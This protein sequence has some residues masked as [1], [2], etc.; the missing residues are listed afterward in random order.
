MGGSPVSRGRPGAGGAPR[1]RTQ[2]A[3][4]SAPLPDAVGEVIRSDVPKVRQ[5]RTSEGRLQDVIAPVS[6]GGGSR[7]IAV[8]YVY[9]YGSLEL[10]TTDH[11][12]AAVTAALVL[13]F[14]GGLLSIILSRGLIRPVKV[15]SRGAA[16][17]AGGDRDHRIELKTG[18][19]MEHLALQF[20]RMVDSLSRKQAD[21]EAANVEL[22]EANTRLRE[23][24]AQL[25]RSERLA[26]LGQLSAGVS[27][28]LDNPVGVILGYAELIREEEGEGSVDEYASII[29]EEAKR[30]KRIIAGLLDFSRPSADQREILDI[31]ILIRDLVS[32]LGEQRTFRD[33]RWE[34]GNR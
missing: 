29:L 6:I 21:L 33:I 19:E 24:Q 22:T 11:I 12:R 28:E 13:M 2:P 23:L 15:L 32:Q 26:A 3:R 10:R 20:N 9:S 31:R 30:C 27:H 17:I 4:G 16:R 7:P 18:D 8:R 14:I 1:R 34:A 5:I 25:I